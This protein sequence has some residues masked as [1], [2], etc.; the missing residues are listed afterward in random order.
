MPRLV[1]LNV[2]VPRDIPWHGRVVRT[3]IWKDPVSER[4]VARRLNI[5]GDDQAD[6]QGHGGEQR[7]VFVY[8]M[9]S[10]R[11]WQAQLGRYDFV[12]GQFSENFTIDGLPDDVACI[13]DRFQIG[14]AIFEVTAPRATCYR[15][16][17]RMNEPRMASLL[18][19]SGRPG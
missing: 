1:S 11:Y 12:H 17:I 2:G 13:G 5:D 6:R 10:Y 4:R 3:A 9:E 15:V 14:S 8:Q 18:T 16:G 19:A 7:A